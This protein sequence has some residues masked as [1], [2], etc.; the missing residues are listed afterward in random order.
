[1]HAH[2]AAEQARRDDGVVTWLASPG[3]VSDVSSNKNLAEREEGLQGALS[4][5]ALCRV[6][7]QRLPLGTSFVLRTFRAAAICR[8]FADAVARCGLCELQSHPGAGS[9]QP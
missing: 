4:R 5:R 3:R 7:L 2:Y 1:M 9:Q 6:V 8:R